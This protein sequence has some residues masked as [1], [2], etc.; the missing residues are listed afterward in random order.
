MAADVNL[1]QVNPFTT[2]FLITTFCTTYKT[3]PKVYH[4][5]SLTRWLKMY[6]NMALSR[7][8]YL[9]P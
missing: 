8:K 7:T 1:L 2:G 5:F 9:D 3:G 6:V 4:Q